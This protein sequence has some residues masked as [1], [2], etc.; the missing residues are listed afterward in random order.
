MLSDEYLAGAQSYHRLRGRY[1]NPHPR[2]TWT[3]DEFERGW[4]QQHK[5]REPDERVHFTS[6]GVQG[7]PAQD[8]N[9]NQQRRE[10]QREQYR[11]M[12]QGA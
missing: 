2:G 5:K 8:S 10:R 1:Q 7:E 4:C 6:P 3:H 9:E 11:R 12:K